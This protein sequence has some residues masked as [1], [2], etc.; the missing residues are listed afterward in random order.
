MEKVTVVLPFHRNEDILL[1]EAIKSVLNS[2]GVDIELILVDN[3]VKSSELNIYKDDRIITLRNKVPGYG[4]SLN[5]GIAVAS[6]KWVALMNSDDLVLKDKLFSQVELMKLENTDLCIT[7][8]QKFG[9]RANVNLTGDQPRSGYS[10]YL[11]FLGAYGANA[12]L[13]FNSEKIPN[14]KFSREFHADWI[15]G[16]EHFF[17]HSISYIN[18]PKY[19]YR[20]HTGQITHKLTD[21]QSDLYEFYSKAFVK[22]I[23]LTIAEKEIVALALPYSDVEYFSSTEKDLLL[24]KFILLRQIIQSEAIQIEQLDRILYRRAI[25]ILKNTN[26]FLFFLRLTKELDISHMEFLKFLWEYRTTYI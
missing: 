20:T 15:L 19:L 9:R 12:T 23:G 17:D 2:S 24:E 7:A 26:D 6:S 8:M 14:M 18:K 22:Q 25:G 4:L 11:L 13:M 16:L 5:M 21:S 1:N 10:P 3:R